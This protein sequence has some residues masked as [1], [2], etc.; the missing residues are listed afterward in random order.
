MPRAPWRR[1]ATSASSS[2]RPS[3]RSRRSR[4]RTDARLGRTG[5]GELVLGVPDA[6]L[7]LP[8]VGLGLAALDPLE[9]GL[10]LLEL[11]AA[12]GRASISFASTASSTR[13][14]ARSCSTLK[15]PGP[16][17]NSRTLVALAEC[18]RVEP[19]LSVAISGAW[20]ASTPISPSAPGTISISASPS[21]AAPSG[22]TS[23]TENVLSGTTR[24]TGSGS[25]SGSGCRA[26][27]RP[28]R[29]ASGSSPASLRPFSTAFSIVPTM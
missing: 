16:V 20:R 19:A 28:P 8:A 18:T 1:A 23:E 12:H 2:S 6:L 24:S 26:R 25:G 11:G 10:R 27:A 22:V 21:N 9:L 3:A 4:T 7:D 15:K 14:I 5:S 29:S 13:A 17:A